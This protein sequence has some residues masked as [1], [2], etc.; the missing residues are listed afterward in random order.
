MSPDR[1]SNHSHLLTQKKE[2]WKPNLHSI[3]V[4]FVDKIYS[5]I[6]GKKIFITFL[7]PRVAKKNSFKGPII[8]FCLMRIMI[9]DKTERPKNL[10]R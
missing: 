1:I 5:P 10:R 9:M 6:E 3:N 7:S 8:K 4:T 2:I